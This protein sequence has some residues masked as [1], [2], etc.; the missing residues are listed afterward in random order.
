MVQWLEKHPAACSAGSKS[1]HG[2]SGW[3]LACTK[4]DAPSM[5]ADCSAKP[6]IRP[7]ILLPE[8]D[9]G[10]LDKSLFGPVKNVL[11]KHALNENSATAVVPRTGRSSV[12]L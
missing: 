3:L 5:L 8:H 6:Q 1:L 12:R 4:P 7:V 9:A 2:T 11:G 10:Q